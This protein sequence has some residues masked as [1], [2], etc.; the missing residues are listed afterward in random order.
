MLIGEYIHTLDEKNRVSLPA[1]FRTEFG[2]KVVLAPGLDKSIFMFAPDEWQ[3][4]ASRLAESSML[5][6]DNRSFNRFLFGGAVE[7]EVDG[8]GRILVPDFLKER[9]GLK[10]NVAIIG[11][12]NRV[13][14]WN[15]KTWSDY[16]K[17]V[18]GQADSLAEKLGSIGVL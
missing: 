11:V 18:E 3:K 14:I 6:T 5:Q 9:A 2:K 10:K 7:V 1:K 15:E 17:N 13:E 4:I 16:K 8:S 12:S